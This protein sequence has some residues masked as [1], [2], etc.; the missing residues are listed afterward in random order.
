MNVYIL[1]GLGLVVSL[2]LGGLLGRLW[3]RHEQR[4]I[5]KKWQERE[6]LLDRRNGTASRQEV[7]GRRSR[8]RRL[9]YMG[10]RGARLFAKGRHSGRS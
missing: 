10:R 2:I 3:R 6:R 9:T 5:E 7:L 8:S 4:A 1:L